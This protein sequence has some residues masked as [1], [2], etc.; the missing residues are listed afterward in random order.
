MKTIAE[1]IADF[2]ST[3]K[4]KQAGMDS[5]LD[6]SAEEGATL[7]AEQREEYDTLKSESDA[8]EKHLELLRDRQK[9]EA[10]SAKPATP[11]VGGEQA[12]EGT[13]YEIGKGLQ[14]R[15]KN[16]QKL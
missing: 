6:K 15:A 1:Q 11:S 12:K 16:T 5:I 10:K 14:V 8:I 13:G 4:Q 3:L 9:R 7:D 2:E